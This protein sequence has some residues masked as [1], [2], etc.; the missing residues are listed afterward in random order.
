VIFLLGTF[1]TAI[2]IAIISVFTI[3]FLI[4]AVLGIIALYRVVSAQG[5]A[6]TR[7]P[8]LEILRARYARGEISRE[9]Y[10]EKR[11]DLFEIR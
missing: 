2:I 5:E 10:N 9:E 7:N 3:L 6:K 1:G 11:K 4:L 8:Y